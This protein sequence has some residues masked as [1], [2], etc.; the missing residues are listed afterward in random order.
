MK[1][2]ITF[3][4]LTAAAGLSS[5][6][7]G[8][9]FLKPTESA[10]TRWKQQVSASASRL[11]DAWWRIFEDAELN[12]LVERVISA[13]HDI[14]AAKARLDTARSL[15]GTDRARLFPQLGVNNGIS[16]SRISEATNLAGI[17][18]ESQLYRATFDLSYDPDL[19]GRNR[20]RME[21][22]RA[23]ADAR[24]NLLDAQR[25]GIAAETARQYF[26]LR[27]LDAQERVLD[28]ILES[29]H[30]SLEL[31]KS[32]ATA[33]LVD[34]QASSRARTE[35]ELA[36][37]DLANLQRQ[38]GSAEHALAVLCGARPSD[39]KISA[40]SD[41]RPGRLPEIRAGL[42]AEVI[43]RRPDMRA[44]E[45]RL[46]AANARI[47]AAQ[48]EFYPNIGLTGSGGLESLT[49][50]SFLNWE[51][52]VLSLGGSLAAPIL[53]GGARG[54]NYDASRSQYEESM[55][56]Y[57]QSLLV[58]LREV[59][60][61]LVD[62]KGLA[63]SRMALEGAL[64]GSEDSRRL[65]RERYEKGLSSYLEVVDADRVVLS[66]RLALAQVDAQQRVSCTA[67]ARA[68][69]GGWNRR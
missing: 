34:G 49:G 62:L 35:L 58:A 67:L 2:P 8:P 65:S 50:G 4:I 14:A 61:A 1:N 9:D 53:D 31:E 68:L 20:R 66:T 13:N 44:A 43:A 36:R 28:E 21:A 56:A 33:G 38:R 23:E 15:V 16:T 59:E 27:G 3:L 42:P 29:R 22:S 11:P 41:D 51:S 32:R 24:A 48:A 26:V 7:V 69:G 60:D 12:R 6:M 55:A 19:W 54:A 39:F 45:Q 37:N 46:R 10:G 63:R 64:A 18:Q 17:Q 40:S 47:G 52:R 30:Q 57:R 25:L 5:C